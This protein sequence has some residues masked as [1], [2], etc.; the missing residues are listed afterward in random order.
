MLVPA[1]MVTR[2]HGGGV[3]LVH[4]AAMIAIASFLKPLLSILAFLVPPIVGAAAGVALKLPAIRPAA[5]ASPPEQ[6]R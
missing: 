3:S 5:R 6:P 1:L 4:R 2:E